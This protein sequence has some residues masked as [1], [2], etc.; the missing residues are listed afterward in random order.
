MKKIINKFC[1]AILLIN[2]LISTTNIY[3][4]VNITMKNSTVNENSNTKNTTVNNT[5]NN[6]VTNT[7][8]EEAK[9]NTPEVDSSKKVYDYANL[10]TEQEEY[11]IYSDIIKFI[12]TYNMDMAIVTIN[13]NNK[14]TSMEYADDFYDYNDFGIGS[15]K[16][17]LL[18]LIDMDKRMMWISTTGYA[19]KMYNDNR[20]D[21]ILDYTYDKISKKDYYGCAS[22]FIE[23]SNYFAKKGV[24]TSAK[25]DRIISTPIKIISVIIP[26]SIITIIFIAIGVS[27]HKNV[28]KQKLAKIYE[29][30][31]KI[32][33]QRDDFVSRHTSKVRIESSSGGYSGRSSTH[34]GSSGR[35]HGGGGRSF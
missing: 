21:A 29:K 17:G 34:S 30:N 13:K 28:K 23:Y 32:S 5:T 1:I 7:I 22:E 20:I 11:I 19:I 15:Q 12:E 3:A 2:I 24:S 4:A 33:V 31:F 18:F 10:L 9:N 26:S 35:S 14:K 8:K 25:D 27:K 16:D 6:T